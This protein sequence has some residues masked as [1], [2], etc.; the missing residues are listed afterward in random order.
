MAVSTLVT[1]AGSATANA[2]VTLVVADQYDED[3]P[4][5]GT[6]WSSATDAEKNAAILWATT[7]MDSLWEWSGFTTDSIQSLLW[8]REGML[9]RNEW[10]YVDDDVIPPEL[11]EA[12]AE[13]AR[14]LL[15]S[16]RAGDSDIETQG[17][18][19]VKAG[20]VAL[21]FKQGVVAKPVPDTVFH[22]IPSSWGTVKSRISSVRDLVRA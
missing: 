14:Q 1:T 17:L 20:P 10:E 13:Y 15:V 7:L 9:K 4:S 12:T 11:Q 3:R 22:L 18:T 5:V 2:Y 6:T 21:Q 8:P 19:A 16:D